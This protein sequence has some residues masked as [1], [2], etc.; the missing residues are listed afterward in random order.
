MIDLP[1]GLSL[2]V[3]PALICALWV[4]QTQYSQ[5]PQG[6][7]LPAMTMA[8]RSHPTT[9]HSCILA[10]TTKTEGVAAALQR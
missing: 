5:A 3:D 9:A 7:G 10:S 8:L 2:I 6:V 4:P 1:S